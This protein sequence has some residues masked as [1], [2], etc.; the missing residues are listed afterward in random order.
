MSISEK[1]LKTLVKNSFSSSEV[2]VS[3]GLLLIYLNIEII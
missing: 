1:I 2:S 3:P